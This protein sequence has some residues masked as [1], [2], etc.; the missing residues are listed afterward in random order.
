MK[1]LGE[2]FQGANNQGLCGVGLSTLRACNQYPDFNVSNIDTSDQDHFKNNNLA[3]PRPEPANIPVHCNQ[4]RCS[5]SRRFPQSVITTASAII[6]ILVFIGA[7]LFTFVKYRRRKQKISS[8]YSEG[9]LSPQQ[10]KDLYRKSPSTLVNLDYYNGCYPLPDDQKAGGGL[11]NEY[12]N[13]FRFN[14]DEVESATQY[15]SEAN[16][17]C[18][19]KFSAMYKGVL[20]DGSFVAIRSIN[21][22]CCKSE[23][24][25]FAKGLSLLTSL[26][27]ENVVKLRG[28]CCSSSRGECYLIY[29]FA[30]MGDLS[31]YLDMEDR[32]GHLLDWSKRVSIIKGIAKGK[33]FRI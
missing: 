6:I 12:L 8:N 17:L 9:K 1:R 30:T 20:R 19:S 27:H 13:K 21:M 32:S 4:T 10:P 26:R 5:K 22:T 15:L 2:G 23:E 31:K 11:A 33:L 25:E 18:K 29:D 28:F 24:A 16:L 14:V 7:G 3:T